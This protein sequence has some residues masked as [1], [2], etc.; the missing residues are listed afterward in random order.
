MSKYAENEHGRLYVLTV[1]SWG[2]TTERLVLAES[3]AAAR[4]TFGWTRDLHESRKVRR[5]TVEDVER[6]RFDLRMA[7]QR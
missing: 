5:A 2:R 6:L 3:L 7:R 1:S 4:G